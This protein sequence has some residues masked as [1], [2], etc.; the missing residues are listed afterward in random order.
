[1]KIVLILSIPGEDLGALRVTGP[2]FE[3]FRHRKTRS[4]KTG[5]V[6]EV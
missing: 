3:N 6:K 5:R 1:M 4:D 2:H